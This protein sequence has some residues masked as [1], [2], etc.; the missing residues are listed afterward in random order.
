MKVGAL[1]ATKSHAER[2]AEEG[3]EEAGRPRAQLAAVV[4]GAGGVV[5]WEDG[6]VT[7]CEGV[8]ELGAELL[9]FCGYGRAELEDERGSL[10]G[11]PESWFCESC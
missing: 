11:R 3:R 5:L 8:S 6:V 7:V 9:A 1:R 4:E 10:A 2:R